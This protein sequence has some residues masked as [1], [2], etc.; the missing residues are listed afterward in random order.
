[1]SRGPAIQTSRGT[2]FYILDPRP[3]EVEIEAIAH[4]LSQLVRFTGQ[5]RKLYTVAQHSLHV[6][7][8]VSKEVAL[9]GLLHDAAEAYVGDVVTPLKHILPEYKKVEW[10][11]HMAIA[12]R[13]DL[14][15]DPITLAE[16]KEADLRAL[17]TESRDL[18]V[19]MSDDEFLI[20]S[21]NGPLPE[22]DPLEIEVLSPTVV[23][24]AFLDRFEELKR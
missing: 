1:M 3:E 4:A 16:V 12:S 13:F 17:A 22:P 19:P 2:I 7:A 5:I 8:L 21:A 14:S 15:T 20:W 11:I 18:M 6:S 24:A 10:R 23:R 9:E